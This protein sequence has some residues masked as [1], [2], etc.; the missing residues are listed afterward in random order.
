MIVLKGK[1]YGI[2]VW[3]GRLDRQVNWTDGVIA[4]YETTTN[5]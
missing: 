4:Y 3:Y 2:L 5:I 1:L